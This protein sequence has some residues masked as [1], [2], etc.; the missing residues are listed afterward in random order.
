MT[1]TDPIDVLLIC[2]LLPRIE[3]SL[4]AQYRV[5][6]APANAVPDD[7]AGKVRA[8]VTSAFEGAPAAL[9][10]K[11]PKLEII[12]SVSVGYGTNHVTHAGKAGIPVTNTPYVLT[13]DCADI[14]LA[15]LIMTS[16]RLAAAEKFVRDGKWPKGGF[17]LA[18]KVSG[19]TLGIVGLG[20]IGGAI[21]QR[22]AAMGMQ[23]SYMNRKPVAGSPYKFV[24]T[25]LELAREN[26][27]LVVA[28]SAG[29]D[30]THLINAQVLEALGP[31]GILINVSRGR[32]VDEKA[33][34]AAL[35]AGKIRGA[36]L[37]VFEDEPNVPAAL[38]ARDDVVLLPHIASA[39]VETRGA[40]GQLALDN[41][42]AFFA[43]KPLLTEVPETQAARE[44]PRS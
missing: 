18:R 26:E 4:R 31:D 27:F 9:I 11:L 25:L 8:L 34:I 29:P 36:G 12:A 43:G 30:A 1:N 22:C 19:K 32:V 24:P 33:L 28:A 37:D 42:E 16:R 21:A 35:E 7:I 10:D 14:A 38:I 2:N 40:M 6:R 15:L 41:L 44:R 17:P 13:D 23:I 3:E 5:H 39:T 20:R